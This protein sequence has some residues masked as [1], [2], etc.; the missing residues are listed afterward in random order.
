MKHGEMKEGQGVGEL[1][2]KPAYLARLCPGCNAITWTN[3]HSR[4]VVVLVTL[5]V[6]Y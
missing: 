2:T 4:E 3:D 5:K 1:E 6:E